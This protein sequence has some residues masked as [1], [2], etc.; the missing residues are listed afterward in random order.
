MKFNYYD[1]PPQKVFDDIKENA[2]KIWNTYSDEF[3]YRS[4][5]IDRIKDIKNIQDNAWYIVAM[6]DYINQSKL[7][8]MVTTETGRMIRK[9][10]GH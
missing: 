10:R 2:T 4:D 6:F 3:G 5:K 8:N 7:L 1:A 9:A